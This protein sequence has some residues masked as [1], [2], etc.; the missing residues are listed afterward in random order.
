MKR[1]AILTTFAA[2]VLVGSVVQAQQTAL[3]DLVYIFK[4][5]EGYKA[6][7]TELK[8]DVQQA[9]L[10]IQARRDRY[11]E[12]AK[13]LGDLPTGSPEFQAL[14]EGLTKE[15]AEINLQ[16]SL[17]QKKFIER[18][19]KM[20]YDVYKE[21]LDEVGYYCQRQRIPLALRFDG[22]P[23]NKDNPELVVKQINRQV[24]Y[25]DQAI[26]I[27]PIIL[28]QLNRRSQRVTTRPGT[29]PPRGTAPPR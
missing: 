11:I 6:A 22:E 29:T 26:D 21:V 20:L 19:A 27:T 13:K 2:T 1:T 4:N 14:E 28:E 24:L 18:E 8:L 3:V 25:H 10:A 12:T 15:K 16:M 9:Q 17:Q 23:L 5:H 7:Q